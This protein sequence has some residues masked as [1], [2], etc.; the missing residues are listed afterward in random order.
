MTVKVGLQGN[1]LVSGEVS[2]GATVTEAL[3][4]GGYEA[5]RSS[6]EGVNRYPFLRWLLCA[7]RLIGRTKFMFKRVWTG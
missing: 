1:R 6:S 3:K 4:R 2:G 7:S 5:A